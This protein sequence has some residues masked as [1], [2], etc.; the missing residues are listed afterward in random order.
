MG[1]FDKVKQVFG[2]GTVKVAMD[3]DKNFSKKSDSIS[4]KI[5][6]SAKSDQE[7]LELDVKLEEVWKTGRDENKSI[8][9]FELGEWKDSTSFTMKAGEEKEVPFTLNYKLLK[10]RNDEIAE[11]AGKVG[12][13]LG[14]LGKMMDAEKSTFW[15]TATCDVKGA[16][17]DPNCSEELKLVD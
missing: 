9:N 4:G 8:E 14:G 1:I 11:T 15:L 6:L 10:S 16:A 7:I 5:L 13:A 12:K 2:I 3:V 17:F